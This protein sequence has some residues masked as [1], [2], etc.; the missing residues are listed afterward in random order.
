MKKVFLAIQEKLKEIPEL[1]HIDED[2]GQ[3]DAY[4]PNP[5]TRFPL[6]LIDIGSLQYQNLGTDKRATPINRQTAT[7]TIVITVANAKLTN[8]SAAAPQGQKDDAWKIQEIIESIHAKIHGQKVTDNVGAMIRVG[9]QR[10]RR[11]DGIQEYEIT[12]SIGMTNV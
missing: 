3:L 4:S 6:A 1:K 7:G 10:I 11:D 2:W 12:Y 8:T 5:P 9:C